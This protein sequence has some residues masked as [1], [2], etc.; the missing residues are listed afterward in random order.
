ME[1]YLTI[2]VGRN[3]LSAVL[4]LPDTTGTH[5]FPVIIICH[6][7]ISNKIGQHR[8]FVQTAR[9]LSQAGHAVIRFDYSGSGESS[10]EYHDITLTGQIA[11][12]L[13]VIDYVAAL[14]NIDQYNITLLGHSLGGCIAASAAGVDD[15]ISRLVL[16]SPV[17]S[18]LEDIV[19]IIGHNIYREGLKTG[20]VNYQGFELGKE[21]LASLSQERPLERI[22][23]FS[24]DVLIVH[25]TD[26]IETPFRNARQYQ[27]V[28]QERSTGSYQLSRIDGADHTYN[29]PLWQQEVIDSTTGWLVSGGV[30]LYLPA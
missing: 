17:A 6:G 14:P 16:W 22:K 10:G 5:K 4:H 26:D 20:V 28:L 29:S 2:P 27:A 13:E 19:G 18:P 12:T 15:R 3:K 9:T 24:G 11:E 7:F 8:L 25:G 21:F 23:A 1:Q 30:R